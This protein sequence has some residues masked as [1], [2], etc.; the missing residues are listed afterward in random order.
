MVL[1]L[2]NR[3]VYIIVWETEKD[4]SELEV[5]FIAFDERAHRFA[6][7]CL[8]KV[9]A[10]GINAEL[11]PDPVK[12]KKQMKYANARNVPNVILIGD[13]EMESGQLSLKDMEKGSQEQLTIEAI[14]ERLQGK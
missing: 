8:T 3:T 4:A 10:A 2:S 7:K 11:Y 13:S 14:I 1:G 9:R 12:L 5:L 6:F